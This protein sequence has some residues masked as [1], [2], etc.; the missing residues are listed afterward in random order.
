M[1]PGVFV[2]G[3]AIGHPG[4]EIGDMACALRR[5]R[6]EARAPVARQG[7]GIVPIGGE[8]AGYHLARA[9]GIVGVCLERS[10]FT[11]MAVLE[12]YFEKV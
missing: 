1:Q 6:R 10:L 2:H 3:E 9:P 4:D 11:V 8:Q 5:V 12:C 7:G